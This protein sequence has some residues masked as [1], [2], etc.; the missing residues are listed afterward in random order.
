MWYRK[1]PLGKVL[2]SPRFTRPDHF[3]KDFSVPHLAQ[4]R[5]RIQSDH[6]EDGKN[7]DYRDEY[8]ENFFVSFCL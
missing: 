4:K 6:T 3:L 8:A 1:A 2:G 7:T 5:E